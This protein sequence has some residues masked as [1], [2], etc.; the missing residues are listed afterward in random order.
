[1]AL[2]IQNITEVERPDTEPSDY[3][4]RINRQ[5]PLAFFTHVRSEGAAACLRR[6][7]DAIDAAA[8]DSPFVLPYGTLTPMIK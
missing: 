8:E 1:M 2:W 7:A 4:V 6:A 5:P 3:A